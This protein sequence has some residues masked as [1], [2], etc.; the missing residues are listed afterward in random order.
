MAL[1][2]ICVF[3]AATPA[4]GMLTPRCNWGVGTP[5]HFVPT[6]W[7]NSTQVVMMPVVM[8]FGGPPLGTSKVAFIS[9][10]NASQINRDGGGVLRIIDNQ[11]NEIARFPDPNLPGVSI[12]PPGCPANILSHY[13]APVSGLAAGRIDGTAGVTIVAVLDELT[14]NHKQLV[15]LKLSGGY[16][17]PRWCSSP[18]PL[19]D[20]IPGTTAP[21]IAQ[22]DG[23]NSSSSGL[24]EIIIDNKV[25][26]R[27]GVL[28][29]TGFSF[30]GNCATSGGPPCPRSRTAVVANVLGPNMLPQVITGRGLYESSINLNNSLWSGTLAWSNSN[31]TNASPPLVYPAV[32]E[33]VASS[34]GPEIVVTDTMQSTVRV[35]SSSNGA[36]LASAVLPGGG[37]CGGPPMIGDADGV[38]GP[39]IGVASCS[40][41]TLFKYN[42]TATLTQVWK[43]PISDP[44]GQTASAMFLNPTG[45]RIFYADENSLWVFDG[46]MNG[47]VI[48]TIPTSSSTAIEGPVIAA[49]DHATG[50]R[51]VVILAANNYLGG[52]C[53]GVKIF[54]D[55]GSPILIGSASS[56][57]NE[58]SY[59]F[60]NVLDSLGTIP[61][62]EADS[63]V[64]PARNTY[65]VQQ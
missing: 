36:Q 64:S 8:D 28:R 22:L 17:T 23:P 27:Y 7:Q 65:R 12:I 46:M 18:L 62:I 34:P 49:L 3:M 29:Y 39:E 43:K 38:P 24:S 5:S 52:C 16:L 31:I 47:N 15:G 1:F 26:D 25:Y 57:W 54:N 21:A 40:F 53:K 10:E 61:V 60:T 37:H 14:S 33:I 32:A 50:D 45:R 13:L 30:G 9:F 4:H 42:N 59:H 19:G 20:F 41:Y 63:W 11:C 55:L 48:Q 6:V 44:S 35:L 2:F 56:F 58:H 51:G